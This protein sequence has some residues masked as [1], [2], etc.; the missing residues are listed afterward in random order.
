MKKVLVVICL[1]S[2]GFVLAEGPYEDAVGDTDIAAVDTN[3]VSGTVQVKIG[4]CDGSR[5]Q[6][7]YEGVDG[8]V[9]VSNITNPG[10]AAFGTVDTCILTYY[11][12]LFGVKRIFQIDTLANLPGTS[13]VWDVRDSVWDYADVF[14]F[15]YYLADSTE[16]YAGSD[17]TLTCLISRFFRLFEED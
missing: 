10:D 16:D 14:Y 6:P 13:F 12:E 3:R 2:V 9:V 11:T 17:D 5:K 8:H 7:L 15:D 1:L 4:V